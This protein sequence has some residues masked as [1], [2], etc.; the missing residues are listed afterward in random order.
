MPGTFGKNVTVS[1]HQKLSKYKDIEMEIDKM[2]GQYPFIKLKTIP[3]DIDVQ[4]MI[5]KWDD[6]YL[7]EIAR[8]PQ[9]T[10]IQK[11]VLIGSTHILSV[12]V[13]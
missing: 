7:T 1:T 12:Y 4:G 6:F 3:V 8:N 10:K 9:V 2:F 11:I 5:A 13:I